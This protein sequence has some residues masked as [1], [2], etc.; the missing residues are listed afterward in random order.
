MY[1][2][3]YL[4]RDVDTQEQLRAEVSKAVPSTEPLQWSRIAALPL[5]DAICNETMRLHPSVLTA[6]PRDSPA[7]GITIDG[8]YIPPDT[9]HVIPTY[10]L[11]RDERYWTRP[12][13]WI[14]ARWLDEP[15]LVKDKRAFFPF[16]IGPFNCA[17][18]YLSYMEQK[19]LLTKLVMAFDIGFASGEDGTQI[20]TQQKDYLVV[21]LPDVRMCLVP[22]NEKK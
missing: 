5:L 16:S 20:H 2:L 3:Y 8:V 17:G 4:S 10:T 7:E 13:E 6:L 18:K 12:N 9:Q 1:L 19:I 15:E 21:A 11:Q 14:P 22:R